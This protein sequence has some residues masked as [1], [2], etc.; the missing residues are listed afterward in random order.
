MKKFIVIALVFFQAFG[1][2]L[3]GVGSVR[4]RFEI[5]NGMNKKAYGNA[6]SLP[7]KPNDKLLV[8]RIKLGFIYNQSENVRY[9]V[10]AYWASVYGWSLG[11][12]DFTKVSGE[13][14]YY[15]DPQEDRDFAALNVQV[16]NLFHVKG[17]STKIGRQSN[18]YGDKRVLGPGSWGNSYG[19]LWDLAKISYKFDNN[20]IDAFWGETKDKDKH[21]L[22]L[23]RKHVY[24]GAGIYSHFVY[25]NGA[26]EPFVIY[27]H[28]LYKEPGNGDNQENSYTYGMRAYDKDLYG[29]NYDITYAKADGSI[30]H[31]KYDAYGYAVRVG[32][33]LK[34]LLYS[35]NIVI[36]KIYASG[37]DN[38]KDG[39]VKRFR[40]PFGG[41][42]G[43]LYGRMDIMKWSNLIEKVIELYLYPK[44]MH[45]KLSLHDFSLANAN[46]MWAYYKIF[47]KPG[48]H[49]DHLG[50]EFDVEYKYRYSKNLELQAIYSYFKAGSFIKENVANNNAHRLFLQMKYSFKKLF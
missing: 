38:P 2:E 41:T 29:F 36:G 14:T 43:S 35:P 11:Y 17:L 3:I 19:W 5:L 47:N 45:L 12:S 30:K 49:Y 9:T 44:K 48:N 27:K 40:T 21:R 28:G 39:V 50:E 16:K 46:D 13:H 22:S 4:E 26:M 15:M 20:F 42:D 32:Y 1:G 6:P 34:N 31:K 7:G 33:R 10:I 18:R 24:E 25:G 37:D 23:F 8:N